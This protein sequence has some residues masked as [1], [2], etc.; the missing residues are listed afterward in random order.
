LAVL[1]DLTIYYVAWRN[2]SRQ[3]VTPLERG[4]MTVKSV[5]RSRFS[6]LDDL[7]FIGLLQVYYHLIFLLIILNGRTSNYSLIAL[8]QRNVQDFDKF[9]KILINKKRLIIQNRDIYNF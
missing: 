9:A 5:C 8:K 2:C 6:R 1:L 3:F 4:I 7:I